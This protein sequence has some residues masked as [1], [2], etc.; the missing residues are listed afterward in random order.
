VKGSRL[1]SVTISIEEH[2]AESKLPYLNVN[3]RVLPD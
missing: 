3:V 1:P 2:E